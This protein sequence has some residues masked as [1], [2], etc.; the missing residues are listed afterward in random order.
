MKSEHKRI[1]GICADLKSGRYAQK[2]KRRWCRH[3]VWSKNAEVWQMGWLT[4][5]ITIPD[6][7]GQCPIQGCGAPRPKP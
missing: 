5:Q 7:W 4:W 2:P 6:N 1:A 3:I